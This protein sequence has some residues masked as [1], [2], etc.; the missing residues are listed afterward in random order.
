MPPHGIM[1]H[2]F[3]GGTHSP[4]QGSISADDLG[5]LLEHVGEDR[6]LPARVWLERFLGERL[7]PTD[8]CL[9]FD[10]NLRCQFDIAAPVLDAYGLTGFWFVSTSVMQGNLERLEI[11][12]A[13]RTR[14][15]PDLD[16]FYAAFEATLA[17]SNCAAEV[18]QALA[19]FDVERYLA[20]FPF[21]TDADRRFRYIRDVVL[22]SARYEAAMERMLAEHGVTPADLAEN[23]WM[24]PDH[25]RRLHEAGHVIGLHS[26]THPTRLGELA[27]AAQRRE[28]VDNYDFLAALLPEPPIAMSHPCNSYDAATVEIL[29]GL[30]IRLGFRANMSPGHHGRLEVPRED[31]TNLMRE[32]A[33]CA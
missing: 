32:I 21:Y 4:G 5:K 22:G 10:D 31:H 25:L 17:A 1:F 23:L 27:P 13:F 2:H 7:E 33:E 20:G 30:G 19:A 28:Y 14:C 16:A 3:H 8:T 26:H 11:Y 15:F 6:I 18:E 24:T 29:A 9:T 12:R